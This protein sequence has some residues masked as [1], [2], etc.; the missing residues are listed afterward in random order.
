MFFGQKYVK[1]QNV[2]LKILIFGGKIFQNIWIGV[3][4]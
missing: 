4:S 2:Y 1:Y 3:F